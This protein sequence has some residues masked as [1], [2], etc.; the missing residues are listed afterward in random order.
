MCGI[1]LSWT[2]AHH[3]AANGLV[4]RFHQTLKAAIICHTDQRWT[5]ALPLVLLRIHM[6]FKEDLQ[7]SVTELVYGEPLRIPGKL[8]TLTREW[9]DPTGRNLR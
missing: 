4:K 7:A 9:S 6:S 5:E 1:Q 2:T 8:L 3:P